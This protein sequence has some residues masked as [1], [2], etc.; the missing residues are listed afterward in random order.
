MKNR[1]G[2]EYWLQANN[3]KI[4]IGGKEHVI[5]VNTF[6]A[7]WPYKRFVISVNAEM[8]NKTDPEYLEIK[9]KLGNDWATDVLESGDDVYTDVYN[10]LFSERRAK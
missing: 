3:K 2:L 1:R 5:K 6:L 7:K 9:A 4:F 10:Q 8:I